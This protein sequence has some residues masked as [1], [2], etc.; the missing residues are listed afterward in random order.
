MIKKL[1]LT[2]LLTYGFLV[3]IILPTINIEVSLNSAT[4]A[5]QVTAAVAGRTPAELGAGLQRLTNEK[6]TMIMGL[7]PAATVTLING[8]LPAARKAELLVF[9]L[10]NATTAQQVTAAVAGR[11]AAELGVGLQSLTNEKIIMIMGLAPAATVTL[12]NGAL[13][14][15]RK[16]ELLVFGLNNATTAQQVTAAVAGR[17]AAELGVG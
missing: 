17:T 4:T 15:P 10:N 9:G 16:A 6:I 5:Q 8:A 1:N 7:A 11:T 2:V 3:G 12:I 14:A 13:P